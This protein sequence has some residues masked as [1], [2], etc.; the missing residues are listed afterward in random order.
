M[1][2]TAPSTA[3]L[4]AVWFQGQQEKGANEDCT[5]GG[6]VQCFAAHGLPLTIQ[7]LT[8]ALTA[9]K[10]RRICKIDR[11]YGVFL[12]TVVCSQTTLLHVARKH[13]ERRE[14]A[15]QLRSLSRF[16]HFITSRNPANEANRCD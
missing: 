15:Q 12:I 16:C 9:R 2:L 13:R 10:S 6:G 5:F 3:T 4:W 14:D 11:G 1:S 8:R 7:W